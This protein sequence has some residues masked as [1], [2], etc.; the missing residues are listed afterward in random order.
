M[1]EELGLFYDPVEKEYFLHVEGIKLPDATRSPSQQRTWKLPFEESLE[2]L[3][4]G[5]TCVFA[6]RIC[7]EFKMLPAGHPLSMRY[8]R[9][10][11]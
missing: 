6:D 3:L 2:A 9:R 5:E 10:Q 11:L 4:R 1:Q 7:A 8:D